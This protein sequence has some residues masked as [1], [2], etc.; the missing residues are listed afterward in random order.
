M[1]DK[2]NETDYQS[3][4]RIVRALEI[5]FIIHAE[6]EL[7]SSTAALRHLS[8]SGADVYTCIAGASATLYG[9][10][11]GGTSEEVLKML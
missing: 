1:I 5:L 6:H 2:L 11:N 8:S 7:N 10:K 9:C 4:P 3:N